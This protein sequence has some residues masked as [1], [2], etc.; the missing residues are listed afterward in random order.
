MTKSFFIV[1]IGLNNAL[2]F[3]EMEED[4]RKLKYSLEKPDAPYG[5]GSYEA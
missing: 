1:K 3:V 4:R 5:M 2:N